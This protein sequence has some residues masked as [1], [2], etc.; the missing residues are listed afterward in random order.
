MSCRMVKF[1]RRKLHEYRR[2][3]ARRL[4]RF[5]HHRRQIDRDLRKRKEKKGL[6]G[7]PMEELC[8]KKGFWRSLKM[9][10]HDPAAYG[11]V[12]RKLT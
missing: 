2:F 1:G 8:L 12:N 7:M 10:D 3:P 6:E 5:Q 11:L 4:A 9:V